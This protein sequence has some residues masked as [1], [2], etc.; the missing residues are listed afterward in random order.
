[1]RIAY[2]FT[3]KIKPS[4]DVCASDTASGISALI[5]TYTAQPMIVSL[6]SDLMRSTIG[7]VP[8]RFLKFSV[9][10]MRDHCGMIGLTDIT[11]RACNA[12]IDE[13]RAASSR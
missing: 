7:R 1:M 5:D 9:G 12:A 4:C 10:S 13:R 2:F 3:T 8:T 6:P 11:P